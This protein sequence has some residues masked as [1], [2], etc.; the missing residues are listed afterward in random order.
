MGQ[1][2]QE[3]EKEKVREEAVEEYLRGGVTLREVGAK[4]GM[5]KTT[6]YRSVKERESGEIESRAERREAIKGMPASVRELQ[7]ELYEARLK[8]KLFETMIDIAEDEMGIVIRKK[9]GAKQ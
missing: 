6:L 1:M 4:Y 5:S 3:E 9:S 8:A 2:G 7:R